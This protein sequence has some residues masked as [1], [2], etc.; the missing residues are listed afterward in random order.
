[1]PQLNLGRLA[2]L[3]YLDT[4]FDLKIRQR[5]VRSDHP[6]DSLLS[7]AVG[8]SNRIR[9]VKLRIRRPGTELC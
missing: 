7:C 8:G 3:C 4:Q 1:M 9:A 2:P 5:S 6:A